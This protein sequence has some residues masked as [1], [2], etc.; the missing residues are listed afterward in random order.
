MNSFNNIKALSL[1]FTFLM[2]LQSC[3]V[4]HSAP[5]TLEEAVSSADKV[6]IKSPDFEVYKFSNISF[7]DGNIYGLAKKKSS[8]AKALSNQITVKTSDQNNVRILLTEQ[9]VLSYHLKNRTGSTLATIAV[10]VVIVG[11][12]VGI[13]YVATDNVAVGLNLGD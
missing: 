5:S 11:A 13:G 4:Y 7:L 1:I 3:T 9:N 2:L 8:T 10:P 6:K 12:L